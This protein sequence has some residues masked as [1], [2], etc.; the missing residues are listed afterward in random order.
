MIES[1]IL[2]TSGI[3]FDANASYGLLPEVERLLS[4]YSSILN[5]SSIHQGG[6][7]S[8]ALIEESRRE[9]SQLLNLKRG[10]RVI[11]TSGATEANNTALLSKYQS[12]FAGSNIVISAIE[13]P[14]IRDAA[15]KLS[16]KGVEVREAYPESN[17][18]FLPESFAALCDDQT[19]CVSVML[20][21][22]ET[23]QVLPVQEIAKA[24]KEVSPYVLIHVDA[25]QALGK[26]NIDFQ[27]LGADLLSISAHKIGGLSG[28]GA[29]V[30]RD[31]ISVSPLLI[32]GPQEVRFRAG[33]E[34]VLGII[35]FGVA[36]RVMREQFEYRTA[37]MSALK[38][39]FISKIKDELSEFG[40]CVNFEELQTL[41]NTISL[42]VP[43]VSAD[44]L[45]VALDLLGVWVSAGAACS[46]GKPEPSHVLLGMGFTEEEARETIRISL[47]SETTYEML[48]TGVD[49]IS[50]A[51]QRV[52]S[53]DNPSSVHAGV[54]LQ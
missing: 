19:R 47:R 22:N 31:G 2:S 50:V 20:A 36:A 44:D 32:G 39:A 6:Q 17:H 34:N 37:R 5:P 15:Y 3:N 25:V 30:V 49:K 23:G 51:V 33:T 41:P 18:E 1:S 13:H 29:L 21:N 9:I 8:R 53:S 27:T 46:S 7:R 28:V 4:Q 12:T 52:L 14:S 40:V 48:C 38:A 42:R 11:F 43:G 24:I 45:L 10:D 26:I 16:E 54:S 35:S